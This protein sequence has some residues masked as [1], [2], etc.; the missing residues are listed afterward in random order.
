MLGR[1]Q[2]SGLYRGQL[3]GGGGGQG[4]GGER[5]A[6][7]SRGILA[8]TSRSPTILESHCF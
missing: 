7:A 2:R 1:L 4:G 5:R 3:T 8:C 6:S